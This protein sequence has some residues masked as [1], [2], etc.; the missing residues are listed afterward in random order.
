MMT[1][2]HLIRIV[3]QIIDIMPNWSAA[4]EGTSAPPYAQASCKIDM[5][6][7][8]YSVDSVDFSGVFGFATFLLVAFISS[9]FQPVSSRQ[10]IVAKDDM[11]ARLSSA[12]CSM[13]TFEC[14]S[15]LRL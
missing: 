8:F 13:K 9:I 7:V 12:K 6:F 1:Y 3:L 4:E 15:D 10:K 2:I 5:S 11:R 14:V